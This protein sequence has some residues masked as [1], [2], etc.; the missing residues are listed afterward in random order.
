MGTTKA[1]LAQPVSAVI[2]PTKLI[3]PPMMTVLMAAKLA[4][5]IVEVVLKQNGAVWADPVDD[6]GPGLPARV[7]G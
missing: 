1:K 3:T 2:A 6:V 4:A 7:T 5:V